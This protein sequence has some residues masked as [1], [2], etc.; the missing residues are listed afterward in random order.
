MLGTWEGG[1]DSG[2]SFSLE[3]RA[4]MVDL[5]VGPLGGGLGEWIFMLG[6]WIFNVGHLGGGLG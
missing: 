1:W 2:S 3:R 6:I 5:H 4:G